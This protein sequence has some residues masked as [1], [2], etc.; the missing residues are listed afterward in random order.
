MTCH[1]VTASIVF[2]QNDKGIL[3]RVTQHHALAAPVLHSY[4]N[5]LRSS[6]CGHDF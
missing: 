6:G 4:H 2:P 3:K 5:D 1:H